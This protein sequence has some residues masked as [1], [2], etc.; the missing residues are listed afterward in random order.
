MYS[1]TPQ[2]YLL[3]KPADEAMYEALKAME[4]AGTGVRQ[5]KTKWAKVLIYDVDRSL[6]K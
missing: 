1:G 4:G 5:D 2:G 3:V 6:G